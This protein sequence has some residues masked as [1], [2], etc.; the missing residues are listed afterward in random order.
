MLEDTAT[1]AAIAQPQIELTYD[2][3]R[4]NWSRWLHCSERELL[5]AVESVGSDPDN[6]R[7]FLRLSR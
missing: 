4:R 6:V 1:S 7:R 2:W 3:E 5:W